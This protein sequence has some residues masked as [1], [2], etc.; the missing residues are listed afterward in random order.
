MPP[1]SV[2]CGILLLISYCQSHC[3]ISVP[4]T[5]WAEPSI[6]WIATAMPTGSGKTPLFVFLTSI[7]KRVRTKLNVSKTSPPWLLDE[8]SFEKMG[9]LMA[10]N[11][12]KLLGLYDELSTF[13]GTDQCVPWKRSL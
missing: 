9:D 11:H 10:S 1:D 3:T 12:C 2:L 4:G 6:L 8:A 13:F 5:A 7:L